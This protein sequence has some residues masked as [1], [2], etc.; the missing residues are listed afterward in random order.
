MMATSVANSTR[1]RDLAVEEDQRF[2][3]DHLVGLE[4]STKEM[5]RPSLL[6]R[7]LPT[8]PDPDVLAAMAN[9][10]DYDWTAMLEGVHRVA[11]EFLAKYRRLAVLR[12]RYSNSGELLDRL[13][14]IPL[15]DQS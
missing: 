9:L 15:S 4:R 13:R 14:E 1:M 12:C 2:K 3:I 11:A 7:G 8:E 6:S 10:T 5:L